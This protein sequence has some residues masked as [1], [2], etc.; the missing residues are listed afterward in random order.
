VLV[1]RIVGDSGRTWIVDQREHAALQRRATPFLGHEEG[2]ENTPVWVQRVAGGEIFDDDRAHLR[3]AFDLARL[4]EIEASPFVVRALDKAEP[5]D[6]YFVFEFADA[7][8]DEEA[9]AGN[10]TDN[11]LQTVRANVAHALDAVHSAGYVH[12]DVQ[13]SNIMRVGGRWKLADLG[14]A[15]PVG[16]PIEALP[17]DR[18]FVPD[19]VDFGTSAD[20]ALDDYGLQVVIDVVGAASAAAQEGRGH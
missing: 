16:S 7:V 8:L 15:V 9:A 14:A 2:R 10:L 4:P 20:P 5:F 6:S 18:R 19:G 13:P 1:V 11:E 17:R 3:R 12:C